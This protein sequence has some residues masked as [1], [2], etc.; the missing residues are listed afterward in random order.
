M[1]ITHDFLDET[2]RAFVLE[3]Y[4]AGRDSIRAADVEKITTLQVSRMKLASLRGLE[5]FVS[6]EQLDCAYNYLQELDI[7]R[8]PQLTALKCEGN[9]LL[10]LNTG[11]NPLLRQ[12]NC[13]RNEI[14]ALDL[15]SNA[16]LEALNCGSNR[17]RTLE[18][19]RNERL[20]E[21]VCHWNLL[22]ELDVKRNLRLHKLD[23]SYNALFALELSENVELRQLD[24]SSNHLLSL[25]IESC[26][27]LLELRCH[28]NHLTE[29]DVSGNPALQSLRCFNNHISELRLDYP[30]LV[31]VYC[32]ENKLS[33]LDT[34][35]LPLLERLDYAN[36]LIREPD[37]DIEGVGTF[38]YDLSLTSYGAALSYR[39]VEL[40]AAVHVATLVEVERLAPL[41]REAWERMETL[42]EQALR[43]IAEQHPG[44][45]VA[46]LVYSELSFE[47]DG[48][49]RIG[50][51]AGDTDAGRLYIY[52]VFN[53]Q[54]ELDSTLVYE[55]Y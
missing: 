15:T 40:A 26:E 19:S 32:S 48:T 36:N 22:S 6:L 21:L 28:H 20:S 4:C 11:H 33:A 23:C 43:L 46:E 18:V 17:I 35:R 49:V 55:V 41:I 1:E 30:R 51:D 38:R 44:E 34:S 47:E 8:N 9:R 54:L 29:L 52:A 24:C 7:G 27:S 16:E 3:H 25:H 45:N 13:N 37:C 53:R 42:L 14:H 12:L 39:N 2:F 5:H 31:E 50:H 10:W